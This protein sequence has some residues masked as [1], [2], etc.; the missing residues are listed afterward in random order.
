MVRFGVYAISY[1]VLFGIAVAAALSA[2]TSLMTI[3]A[4]AAMPLV[5]AVGLVA[6]PVLTIVAVWGA[7]DVWGWS[8]FAAL[9][10]IA[11][12]H[13][14]FAAS[15]GCL[16]PRAALKAVFLRSKRMHAAP[17]TVTVGG[18]APVPIARQR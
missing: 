16:T 8:W 5:I 4:L 7:V 14:V 15:S 6:Q 13:A 2:L 3:P 17:V 11:G 9:V 18:E 12:A 1:A 10:M